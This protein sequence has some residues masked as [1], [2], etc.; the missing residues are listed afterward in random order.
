MKRFL[1]LLFLF[2]YVVLAKN[3]PETY[4]KCYVTG[5]NYDGKQMTVFLD[6]LANIDHRYSLVRDPRDQ[7]WSYYISICKANIECNGVLSPACQ[8]SND[9]REIIL[10]D[11]HYVNIT[12]LDPDDITQ[13]A[14]LVYG[15]GQDGR[16]TEIDFHCDED[17]SIGKPVF[18][19]VQALVYKFQWDSELVCAKPGGPD[20]RLRPIPGLG[21]LGLFL[22]LAVIGLILYFVIG[23]VIKIAVYKAKGVEVIPNVEFWKD[24]PHLVKDGFVYVYEGITG[25]FKRNYKTMKSEHKEPLNEQL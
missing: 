15:N 8:K 21:I 23:I 18:K 3:K 16:M 4:K 6:Q 22:L 5:K 19:G 24:L 1:L 14:R 10:G 25:L 20:R 2:A 17:A 12:Q 13:G 11:I 7:Y 9:S